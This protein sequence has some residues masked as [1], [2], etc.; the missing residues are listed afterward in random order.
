[1]LADLNVKEGE[2]VHLHKAGNGYSL[3]SGTPEFNQ[4]IE[5][6][7]YVMKKRFEALRELAK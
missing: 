2:V 7:S 4:K 5:A 3:Q 1:M 6:A